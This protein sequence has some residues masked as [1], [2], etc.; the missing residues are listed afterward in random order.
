VLQELV[1][2]AKR[3]AGEADFLPG[4]Y[5]L[6]EPRWIIHLA[7]GMMQQLEGPYRRGE[8]R[9]LPAPDRYRS[10]SVAG[11]NQK[12]YLLIDDA[13]YVFGKPETMKKKHVADAARMHSS[14]IALLEEGSTGVQD[15]KEVLSF[16][17]GPESASVAER[18]G[19]G[20]LIAFKVQGRDIAATPEMREFWMRH[21]AKQLALD[22]P[23]VCPVCRSATSGLRSLP[24]P[25]HILGQRCQ[26]ISF[27]D[28]AFCS[29]GKKQNANAPLCLDCASD[30]IAVL[31]YLIRTERHHR[32]L[33]SSSKEPSSKD[34]L[35]V[36]WLK[37]PV[38]NRIGENAYD[39]Q[40]LLGSMIKD[41]S[42]RST[43]PPP[44]LAQLEAMLAVPWTAKEEALNV[45]G[46]QFHLAILSA[47]KAR[48]V[49]REW[50]V[51]SVAKLQENVG[52][53]LQA[54][55]LVDPDETSCHPRSISTMVENLG[56]ERSPLVGSLVRTAFRGYPPPNGL[57]K[58]A[59]TRFRVLVVRRDDDEKARRERE[60]ALCSVAA[61]IKLSLTHRRK[62]A[63]SMETLSADHKSSPYL[64]GRLLAVL[65]EAQQRASGWRLDNTLVGRFYG[66]ASSAP[67]VALPVLLTRAQSSHLPKVL[68]ENRGY[69][70]LCQLL[71]EVLT[72]LDGTGGFPRVLSLPEQGEFALGF[73]HQRAAFRADRARTS[74]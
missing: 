72:G 21:L 40:D 19:R 41:V 26:I 13:R 46:N 24:R 4:T 2:M 15:L 60:K 12:P 48:L 34:Q 27:D 49:V 30:V 33:V 74:S 56:S 10:G 36:F 62:E 51:V 25:V 53:F 69:A 22:A 11:G 39:L 20:Q 50:L 71:E 3:L 42:R 28:D 23:A 6:K 38:V 68:K 57:L 65:E 31:D 73:Y 66:A 45:A 61:A 58:A 18:I 32:T 8:I 16:I 64:C 29:F 55:R 5:R 35:A 17:R 63:R 44:E 70:M 9:A 1:E 7:D 43:G 59:V 37:E 67:A 14:Y 47:N 54:T 52:A